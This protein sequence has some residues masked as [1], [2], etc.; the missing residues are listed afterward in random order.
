MNILALIANKSFKFVFQN[1]GKIVDQI[2]D[3][4]EH[5]SSYWENIF[6]FCQLMS[7]WAVIYHESILAKSHLDMASTTQAQCILKNVGN[8]F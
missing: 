3:M 5:H 8:I 4:T 7:C 2:V 6:T 1:A